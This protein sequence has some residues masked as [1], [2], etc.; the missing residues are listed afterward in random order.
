MHL[1]VRLA[2]L[3]IFAF[4]SGTAGLPRPPVTGS[5][6]HTGLG[7]TIET[8]P[9]AESVTTGVAA[10]PFARDLNQKASDVTGLNA[11]AP[12][13]PVDVTLSYVEKS[14]VSVLSVQILSGRLTQEGDGADGGADSEAKG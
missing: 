11:D 4:H 5:T 14:D 2:F 9:K 10:A 7:L 1:H 13:R 12:D 8:N 3:A 6:D